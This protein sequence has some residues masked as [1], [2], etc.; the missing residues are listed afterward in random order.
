M[1]ELLMVL[2]GLTQRY[3]ENNLVCNLETNSPS[4]GTILEIK[5]VEGLGICMDAILYDGIMRVGDTLIIGG[6]EKP[7]VTKVK[8]LFEPKSMTDM[9]DKKTKFQSIREVS[10]ATGIRLSAPDIEGVIAG[11]PIISLSI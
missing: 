3:L 9:R 10:A 8:G 7:I 6:I 5:N 2:T 11:M 1:P 4:K